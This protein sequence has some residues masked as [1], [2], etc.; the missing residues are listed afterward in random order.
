MSSQNILLFTPFK[1]RDLELSNR[2]MISPMCTYQ[3]KLDG[4]AHDTHLVHYGQFALGGA[5]LIMTEATAVE[6]RGR[7]SAGDLGLWADDQVE[8]IKRVVDFVHQQGSKIGVQLAH[9]GIKASTR[10]PWEGNGF[11][12]ESDASIGIKPWQTCGPTDKPLANGWPSPIALTKRDIQ[13]VVDAWGA[14]AARANLAGFDV[15]EI[16]GAHGYLISEFLS[17]LT[18][19]RT[20]EY[21]GDNGRTRLACEIVEAVRA[22][23]PRSK[24]L[25]FRMSVIEG[26]GVGWSLDDSVK[27]AKKINGLGVDLIDCSSGGVIGMQGKF[28]IPRTPGYQVFLAAGVREKAKVATS[29]VGL[30]T[31]PKQAEAILQAGQ[32]DL[33]TIGREAL[34]NPYWPRHAAAYFNVDEHFENWPARLGWW[35][36]KRAVMSKASR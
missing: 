13:I 24:P 27:L 31:K 22:N 4:N 10:P 23:W 20:D 29:A 5:G 12:D 11:L 28:A 2:I 16:H 36:D 1:V 35:L 26:V 19:T 33:I 17:P 7:I 14:A 3:A 25:F 6:A 9:A 8:P 34:N 32:A 15:I 18:N 30:I 21:G